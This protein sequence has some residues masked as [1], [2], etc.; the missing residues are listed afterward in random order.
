MK[1]IFFAL[2]LFLSAMSCSEQKSVIEKEIDVYLVGIERAS[3]ANN[4]KELKLVRQEIKD[5]IKAIKEVN[6]E[7]LSDIRWNAFMKE[8]EAVR[9][10]DSLMSVIKRYAA[11]CRD[12]RKQFKIK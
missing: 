12:K 1:K 2:F 9:Q 3:D 7:E 11:V 6:K 8:P 4:I 10:T 5:E